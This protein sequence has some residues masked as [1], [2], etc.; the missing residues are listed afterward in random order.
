MRD[1]SMGRR[2][3]ALTLL[4]G[5]LLALPAMAQRRGGGGLAAAGR[6]PLPLHGTGRGEP[7]L[8]RGRHHRRPEHLLCGGRIGRRL[9][10]RQ[11]RAELGAHLR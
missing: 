10:E 11:Q 4:G 7:H 9:E 6:A 8:G 2:T 1:N 3:L 5:A